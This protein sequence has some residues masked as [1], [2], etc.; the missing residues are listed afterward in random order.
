[1][2]NNKNAK[3][4][5]PNAKKNKKRRTQDDLSLSLSPRA[6]FFLPSFSSIF[7]FDLFFRPLVTVAQTLFSVQYLSVK[8]GM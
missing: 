7:V 5:K 8:A 6:S 2:E 4:N 1:L 3:R